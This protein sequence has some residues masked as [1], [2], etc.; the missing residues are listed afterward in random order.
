MAFNPKMT[1]GSP[2]VPC[3]A[4]PPKF[5]IEI[6]MVG[7]DDRPCPGERYN[8]KCPDGSLRTG[9]L[10]ELGLARVELTQAGTCEISFPDLDKD[11]WEPA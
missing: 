1:A 6:E 2:T 3:P 5:W 10:S 7:E 8:V 9:V 4:A 11:A